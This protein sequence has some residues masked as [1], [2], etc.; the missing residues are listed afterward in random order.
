MSRVAPTSGL[1]ILYL[2]SFLMSLS[3]IYVDIKYKPFEGIKNSYKSFLISSTYILKNITV[4]PF[5]YLYDVTRD[6]S[7]LRNEI[8]VL[9]TEL[10]NI[11]IS[12]FL[13]SNDSKFFSNDES[14]KKI[15]KLNNIN[16]PF[17]IAKIKYF[18]LEKYNCCS[19]HR[20]IIKSLDQ[21]NINF[22]GN[23]VINETGIIGQ[24]IF[25]NIASEVMLLTDTDHVIPVYSKDH[26]CNAKGSGKPGVISC[27][28]SRLLWQSEVEIGQ[29]YFSSG[30]GGIYPRDILIGEVINIKEVDNKTVKF[31]IGLIADPIN[32]N[33]LGVLGTK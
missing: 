13:I 23:P 9:R 25:E 2:I 1:R 33:I 32:S 11:K 16:K 20:I 18:D 22:V 21:N 10:D 19:K 5:K 4:E 30:M 31:D 14:I 26:F 6:K 27:T 8:R 28:F 15:L 17:H 24:V 3:L 12:N 29:K 7:T